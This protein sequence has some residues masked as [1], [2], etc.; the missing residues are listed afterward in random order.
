MEGIWKSTPNIV[1]GVLFPYYIITKP[2]IKSKIIYT[3]IAK[4]KKLVNNSYYIWH[5]LFTEYDIP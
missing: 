1:F 4:F 3:F 2:H 5:Y